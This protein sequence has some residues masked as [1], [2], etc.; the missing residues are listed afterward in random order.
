[1]LKILE[2]APVFTFC[3]NGGCAGTNMKITYFYP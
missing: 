2:M 1:M 3:K